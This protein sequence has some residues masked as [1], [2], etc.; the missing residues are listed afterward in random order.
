M[1]INSVSSVV[2]MSDNNGKLY[3]H[4]PLFLHNYLNQLKI[5]IILL[6]GLIVIYEVIY[7]YIYN[8]S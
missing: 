2:V 1:C 4:F 8:I 7:V 5:I 6:T 3:S